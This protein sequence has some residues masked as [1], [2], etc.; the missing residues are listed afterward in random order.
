MHQNKN[1]KYRRIPNPELNQNIFKVKIK[2]LKPTQICVGFAE[3]WNRI[4]EFSEETTEER[5]S[6]LQQK[7]VPIVKNLNDDLWMLDRHHRLSALINI[8]EESEA[9]CYIVA[10]INTSYYLESLDF[11]KKKGWLYLYN[12]KGIGPQPPESLPQKLSDMEDD[13]YRSLVWKLKEQGYIQR[14]RFIPYHE[15]RWSAWLRTRSLPPF[16]SVNL[17]PALTTARRLV[18]SQAAR[19]IEGWKGS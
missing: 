5:L 4:K 12:S 13:P 7:P 19:H 11:L 17:N 1:L 6:Y 14:K 2:D 18:S 16:N 15:F 9:Y 3:V 10:T 8:D